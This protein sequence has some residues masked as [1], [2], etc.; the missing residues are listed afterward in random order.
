M[1]IVMDIRLETS[2][3]GDYSGHKTGNIEVWKLY[4]TQGL[5][6]K[7]RSMNIVLDIRLETSKYGDCI[8]HKTE[9]IKHWDCIGQSM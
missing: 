7:H 6:R 5:D 8:G 2:K 3:Y 9:N 1:K 4:E